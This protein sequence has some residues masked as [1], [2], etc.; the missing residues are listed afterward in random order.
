MADHDARE[1]LRLWL[2]GIGD[3][4]ELLATMART[5]GPVH[6]YPQGSRT[7]DQGLDYATACGATDP[8]AFIVRITGRARTWKRSPKRWYVPVKHGLRES[9]RIGGGGEDTTGLAF[10]WYLSPDQ[11]N[12]AYRRSQRL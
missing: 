4:R 8:W 12:E 9:A 5:R 1:A 3:D 2:A 11:A 10:A 6:W 7:R